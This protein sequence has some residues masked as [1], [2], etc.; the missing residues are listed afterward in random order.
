MRQFHAQ[1]IETDTETLD[2][3]F[4]ISKARQEVLQ[5]LLTFLIDLQ[6]QQ[7]QK[8]TGEENAEERLPV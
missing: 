4:R 1:D 8:S 3:L 7:T 6:S 2:K 5:E